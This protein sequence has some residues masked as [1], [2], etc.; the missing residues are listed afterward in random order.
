MIDLKQA[1]KIV[2]DYLVSIYP[3]AEN[4]LVEEI[5]MA[6]E[7]QF[8]FIALSFWAKPDALPLTP[9]QSSLSLSDILAPKM[10]RIHKTF[11]VNAESGRV[12]SVKIRALATGI[13]RD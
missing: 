2:Q 7:E 13:I 4:S 8:W 12:L 6:E 10:E 9:M 5:D 1:V 3:D 11:K